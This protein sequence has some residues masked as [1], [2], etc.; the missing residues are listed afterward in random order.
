[1]L[2]PNVQVIEDLERDSEQLVKDREAA[3]EHFAR[4]RVED[5]KKL[6][7][8]IATLES[9][10]E[11]LSENF[12][13]HGPFSLSWKSGEALAELKTTL[14]KVDLASIIDISQFVIACK[15][16]PRQRLNLNVHTF[17]LNLPKVEDLKTFEDRIMSDA[18][19]L[20][21][22]HDRSQELMAFEQEVLTFGHE[23]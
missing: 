13:T 15:T 4:K 3:V 7:S 8:D 1:M 22:E 16:T 5:L 18:E 21:Y 11:S 10:L 6:E 12:K 19:E 2:T 23:I 14:S 9:K 17:S 20:E